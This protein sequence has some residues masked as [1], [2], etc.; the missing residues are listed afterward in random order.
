MFSFTMQTYS[1]QGEYSDFV[2][3]CQYSTF[4]VH[5]AIIWK[6]NYFAK[7]CD[8]GFKEAEMGNVGLEEDEPDDAMA[9]LLFL[10]LGDYDISKAPEC[11]LEWF[12]PR[13]ASIRTGVTCHI[14][15]CLVADKYMVSGTKKMAWGRMQSNLL[16]HAGDD[17][18]KNVSGT[19][20]SQFAEAVNAIYKRSSPD[21]IR[22][23][24]VFAIYR[25][26]ELCVNMV[27]NDI[28]HELAFMSL[29][30]DYA[31][32]PR[33]MFARRPKPYRIMCSSPGPLA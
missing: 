28:E 13:L 16:D 33:D 2:V 23:L 14:G 21:H 26:L 9:L 10:Y 3:K 1:Q 30:G 15:A 5:R 19:W 32:F 24:L 11:L 27:C 8:S 17:F 7:L 25:H 4:D 31:E 6:S 20:A 12:E 18:D 29:F 22:D